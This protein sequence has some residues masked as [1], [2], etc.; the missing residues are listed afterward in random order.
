MSVLVPAR[1]F[2][3]RGQHMVTLAEPL[4]R[5]GWYTFRRHLFV[6]MSW[7]PVACFRRIE[8]GDERS[9]TPEHSCG[10]RPPTRATAG[11]ASEH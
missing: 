5:C 9:K 4:V 7:V 3:S 2:L 1:P 11:A 8:V 10:P 6:S